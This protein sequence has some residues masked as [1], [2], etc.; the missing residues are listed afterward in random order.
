MKWGGIDCELL[1]ILVADPWLAFS[2]L[3]LLIFNKMNKYTKIVFELAAH[4][5]LCNACLLHKRVVAFILPDRF[6]LGAYS[7]YG[8]FDV[9]LAIV[10]CSMLFCLL[11]FNNVLKRLSVYDIITP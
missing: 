1:A 2:I 6:Y 4:A 5:V 10:C 11:I 3:L 9:L 8:S 7:I